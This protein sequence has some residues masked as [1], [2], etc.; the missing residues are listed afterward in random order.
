MSSGS[1][2]KSRTKVLFLARKDAVEARQGLYTVDARQ[3]LVHIHGAELG[4]VE[5]GLEL[6]RDD[7]NLVFAGIEGIADIA[8]LEAGIHVGFA[9][10]L[11]TASE[12]ATSPENATRAARRYSLVAGCSGQR[13]ACS[14]PPPCAN[15]S[16]PSPWPDPGA[17]ALPSAEVFD[18]DR[19]LLLDVVGVQAHPAAV[20]GWPLGLVDLLVAARLV[21][22]AS[23]KARGRG[24]SCCNTSR[25]KP[26]SMACCML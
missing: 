4:L 19:H 10:G 6:V 15:P 8:A 2:T 23:S 7:H 5:A 3:L 13:P 14:A 11:R 26:S 17:G 16:P 12:S 9:E 18:D 20:P 25:M 1:L 22:F 24:C 21:L